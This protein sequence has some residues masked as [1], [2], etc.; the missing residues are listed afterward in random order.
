MNRLPADV[1]AG[2]DRRVKREGL[3]SR[4]EGMIQAAIQYGDFPEGKRP[5]IE[6]VMAP[7]VK[8][9]K[10][11]T[12]SRVKTSDRPPEAPGSRLNKAAAA[13]R[14]GPAIPK[15]PVPRAEPE[16]TV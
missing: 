7:V 16:E 13:K 1:V 2:V 11:S 15:S 14:T 10:P 12:A 3:F 8:P 9:K 6:P 4:N 5:V